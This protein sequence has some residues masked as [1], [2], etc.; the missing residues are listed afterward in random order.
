MKKIVSGLIA[1][2]AIVNV[3]QASARALRLQKLSR[4][5][6]VAG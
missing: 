2:A 1:A 3:S 5:A 6:L 4:P